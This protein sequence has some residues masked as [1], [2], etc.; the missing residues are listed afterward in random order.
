[1]ACIV[2]LSNIAPKSKVISIVMLVKEY[3]QYG[4]KVSKELVE[5]VLLRESVELVIVNAENAKQFIAEA[6]KLGANAALKNEI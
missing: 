2:V 4:L 5:R 6:N 3:T 1:M